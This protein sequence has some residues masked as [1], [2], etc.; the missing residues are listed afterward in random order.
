MPIGHIFGLSLV[1]KDHRLLVLPCMYFVI[2]RDP[3]H[4]YY[5]LC[6][7]LFSTVREIIQF[8]NST[9]FDL[10]WEHSGVDFPLNCMK[11]KGVLTLCYI[12]SQIIDT[13]DQTRSKGGC[14]LHLCLS[15][16]TITEKHKHVYNRHTL[17]L[18]VLFWMHSDISKQQEMHSIKQ[19]ASCMHKSMG[20]GVE[21]YFSSL[22][23]NGLRNSFSP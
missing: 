11:I 17:M 5:V 22:D 21:Q 1:S 19:I 18:L 4:M 8:M 20:M 15:L 10:V 9:P 12:S 2:K 13:G 3:Y 23:S 7:F 14:H 6:T 16:M